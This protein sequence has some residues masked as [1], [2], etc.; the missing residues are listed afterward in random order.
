MPGGVHV[1]K[2][3]WQN[4]AG[5]QSTFVRHPPASGGGPESVGGPM[6]V[7]ASKVAHGPR[8]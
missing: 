2:L 1:P 6:S 5:P 7:P 4:I 8:N 3:N